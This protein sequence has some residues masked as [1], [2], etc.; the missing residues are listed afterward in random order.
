MV[1]LYFCFNFVV[2]LDYLCVFDCFE[3]IDNKNVISGFYLLFVKYGLN[4]VIFIVIG[5]EKCKEWGEVCER[6]K[7]IMLSMFRVFDYY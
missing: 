1:F 5:F 4:M 7:K 2:G 6:L 3:Y